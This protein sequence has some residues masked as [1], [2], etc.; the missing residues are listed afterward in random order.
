[1]RRNVILLVDADVETCAAALTASE[2]GGFDVRFAKIHRDLYEIAEVGL[3][4]VAA[5]VFDYDP[6]VHGPAIVEA[7]ERWV[8]TR[9]LILVSSAED[10]R[11][12]MILAGGTAK[13]LIKP[14][15]PQRLGDAIS[16]SLHDL[17]CRCP[18]CDR[19]GHPRYQWKDHVPRRTREV[20]A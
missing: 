10:L 2:A 14:V 15:S 17:E 16:E 13:H 19:W 12:P 5:I 11:H 8:P 4:D 6:D 3:D 1:M 18:S 9:P 20:A 7:L